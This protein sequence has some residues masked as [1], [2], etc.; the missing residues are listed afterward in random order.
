MK[1]TP[2][3]ERG[4]GWEDSAPRFR[5]YLFSGPGPGHTTSTFDVTEGDVLDAIRWAQL[6]AGND[7]T[8]SVAL[9]RDERQA[10]GN[11]V[12]GLVWLVGMDANDSAGDDEGVDG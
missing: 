8:F 5:V 3:D 12:R 7:R 1:V 9:V 10:G 2:V 11:M 4:S 6:E